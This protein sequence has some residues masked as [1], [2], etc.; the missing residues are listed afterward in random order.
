M[1]S[2]NVWTLEGAT[3]TN[4]SINGVAQVVMD[5]T[6]PNSTMLLHGTQQTVITTDINTGFIIKM[7]VD[8]LSEGTAKMVQLEDTEIPTIIKSTIIYQLIKE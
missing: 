7:K 4:A 1:S 8:N 6:E 2:K 3:N 5:V